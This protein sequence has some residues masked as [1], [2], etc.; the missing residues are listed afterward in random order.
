MVLEKY[1]NA[2]IDRH[3]YLDKLV[4]G[5]VGVGDGGV[6]CYCLC[7]FVPTRHNHINFQFVVTSATIGVT[8]R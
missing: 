3:M 7:C 2:N 1:I 6:S 4:I 5:V 8:T